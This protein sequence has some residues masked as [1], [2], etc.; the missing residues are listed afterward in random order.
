MHSFW[1]LIHFDLFAELNEKWPG[2]QNE[3]TQCWKRKCEKFWG[4]KKDHLLFGKVER[5]N[6]F[7]LPQ[8]FSTLEMFILF[9]GFFFSLTV[10]F[11]FVFVV[12]AHSWL[13]M[14]FR[15]RHF[16][17]SQLLRL[18]LN[19]FSK[20]FSFS[21]ISIKQQFAIKILNYRK[22]RIFLQQHFTRIANEERPTKKLW[23]AHLHL[24]FS[25]PP[26]GYHLK[27]DCIMK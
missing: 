25:L 8:Q 27:I 19:I 14:K 7:E 20:R 26:L 24:A 16:Q 5:K 3:K 18:R 2:I 9:F 12:V 13:S 21:C 4:A 23:S 11:C 10:F 15:L 6:Y 17:H 1:H 22:K